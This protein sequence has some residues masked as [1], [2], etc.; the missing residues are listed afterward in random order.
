[1]SIERVL[2]ELPAGAWGYFDPPYIG[3]SETSNFTA[4]AQGGFTENDQQR[5]AQA[6][7]IASNR[8]VHVLVSNSDTLRTRQIYQAPVVSTKKVLRQISCKERNMADEVLM[9]WDERMT[10][11]AAG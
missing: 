3:S 5:L 11:V 1:M 9:A 4:Y 8:G 2:A 10:A 7:H 6:C